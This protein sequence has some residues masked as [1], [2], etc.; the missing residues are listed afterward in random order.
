[1]AAPRPNIIYLHS[2]DTG[3]YIQPYGYAVPAPNTQRLAESGI[4]FRQA[5]C[6]APTCSPS[7]AALLTGQAAHSSGMAGLAHRGW[8]LDAYDQHLHHRL[9]RASYHTVLAGLQHLHPDREHLGFDEILAPDGTAFAGDV[10]PRAVDFLKTVSE[11]PFFMDVG[12][13]ETHREFPLATA[14]DARYVR[15]PD[16]LPD[17]EETRRDMA[18]YL[19]MVRDLDAGVGLI[20]DALDSNNLG[21]NTLVI[22]TTDH[23]LAFPGM[24]CSLT[25]HGTGVLLIIRG[26]YG[27]SGGRVLDSLVSH[28]DLYP[29]LC[30]LL[31]IP[32][33]DWLQ[34]ESMM[35]LIRG[36]VEEINEAVF[37][38]VNYH[39]AYEPQRSVRTRRFKYIRRYGEYRQEVLPN[40]DDGHSKGLMMKHG[41]GQREQDREQL[42]D[43]VFDPHERNNLVPRTDLVEVLGEMR[44]RLE[45]WM[46]RTEDPLLSNETV[47]P[48]PGARVNHPHQ[49]SPRDPVIEESI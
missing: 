10:A 28:V 38:E 19:S 37:A 41:W 20:L 13:F 25:D 26:P 48:P 29:T 1:M 17:T 40:T 9:R 22:Q 39:A 27:F 6:A 49:T 36:D 3:R 15:P 43:L 2:H 35:P 47:P 4:L 46:Q 12:F 34:G 16:A 30:D 18:E 45:S 7:R 44:S 14:A 5:F 31:E 24:K 32:R 8:R 21:D 33:P 23:G 42:Y 11:E